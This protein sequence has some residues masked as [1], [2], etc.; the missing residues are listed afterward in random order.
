VY[1]PASIRAYYFLEQRGYG[2]VRRFAGGIADWEAAGY[3]LE[4]GSSGPA[5][6]WPA[7]FR[8][9]ARLRA[10]WQFHLQP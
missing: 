8:H 2:R 3:R 10:A 4:R 6:V 5:R 1:C 9:P 7:P